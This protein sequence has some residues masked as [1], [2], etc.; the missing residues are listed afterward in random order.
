MNI[1]IWIIILSVV[2]IV[3]TVLWIWLFLKFKKFE[4]RNK[5]IFGRKDNENLEQA[6]GEIV[7]RSRRN[8]NDIKE[9]YDIGDKLNEIQVN[10]IQKV[11]ISRYNP[12]GD[13]GGDQSFSL[14]ILDARNNGVLVTSLYSRES[15]K[16]FCK[17]IKDGVSKYALT[18]EEQRVLEGRS[19]V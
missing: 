1:F 5:E 12:F 15:S 14:A 9:L 2:I 3:F 17:P 16:V 18:E 4:N 13:S 6:V 10:A 19:K 8:E 7:K 11:R